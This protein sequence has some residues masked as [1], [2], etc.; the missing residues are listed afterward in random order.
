MDIVLSWDGIGCVSSVDARCSTV[1]YYKRD[2]YKRNE[3][4]TKGIKKKENM[5]VQFITFTIK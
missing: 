4:E 5:Y 3:K 1:C 2:Y